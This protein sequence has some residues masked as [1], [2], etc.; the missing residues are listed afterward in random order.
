MRGAAIHALYT[1][2]LEAIEM[3]LGTCSTFF[4]YR[5][6]LTT[7]LRYNKSMTVTFRPCSLPPPPSL[8]GLP[9]TLVPRPDLLGCPQ[10]TLLRIV[11]SNKPKHL[12]FFQNLN[13]LYIHV[14]VCVS[15]V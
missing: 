6:L 1:S 9:D 2:T 3:L 11:F 4:E 7:C 14:S 15:Y 5:R 12:L 13:M 8:P 10:T